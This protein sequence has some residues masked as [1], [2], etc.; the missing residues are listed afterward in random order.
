MNHVGGDASSG[1]IPARE[2]I[3]KTLSVKVVK[4]LSQLSRHGSPKLE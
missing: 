2:V 1:P 4:R 3:G